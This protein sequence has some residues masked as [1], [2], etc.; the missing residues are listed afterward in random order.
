MSRLT[1]DTQRLNWVFAD[2]G[3]MIVPSLLQLV[4]I[5]VMLVFLNWRL[6]I[7][8][9]LPAPGIVLATVWFYRK[10]HT[11][12][13]KVWQRESKMMAQAQDSIS[14]IRVVKAFTQE[15]QEVERFGKKSHETYVT[16]AVADSTWATSY[17]LISF[18][19]MT[20]TFLV[21]YFGGS[22]VIDGQL[23]IGTLMAFFTY[24]GMS[25]REFAMQS[26]T[27]ETEGC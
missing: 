18:I 1:R 6:A 19:T 10:L 4:G 9:L 15:P 25:S 24:L 26:W 8:V 23:S 13:H 20:S 22:R 27:W 17:P 11:L 12:Y 7:L 5:C 3:M 16:T 2:L 21:W 14:G